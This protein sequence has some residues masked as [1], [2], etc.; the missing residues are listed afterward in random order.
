MLEATDTW[1]HKTRGATCY[2]AIPLCDA[3]Q[4]GIDVQLYFYLIN[5]ILTL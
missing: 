5:G 1:K 3:M 2:V 4:G